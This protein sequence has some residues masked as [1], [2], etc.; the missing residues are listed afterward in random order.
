MQRYALSGGK[1]F[2]VLMV[3]W[4]FLAFFLFMYSRFL[5]PQLMDGNILLRCLAAFVAVVVVSFT[6]AAITFSR[7]VIS[8]KYPS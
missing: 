7:D 5:L 6:I 4:L 1:K 2:A 8:G 3:P